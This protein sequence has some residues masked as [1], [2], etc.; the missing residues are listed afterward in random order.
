M[1][2]YDAKKQELEAKAELDAQKAQEAAEQEAKL[3][4]V[5][6]QARQDSINAMAEQKAEQQQKRNLWMIIGGVALAILGFVGNQVLQHFRNLKNQ[7]NIMQMQQSMAQKAQEEAKRRTE[8]LIKSQSQKAVN[9]VKSKT[10]ESLKA[11][12]GKVT[13]NKKSKGFSI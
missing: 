10:K 6:A 3:E 1:S 4:R 2:D 12:V 13:K 11:N 5:I 9:E 8:S 7:K